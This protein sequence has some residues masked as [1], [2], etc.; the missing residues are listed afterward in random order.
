M[1][2]I[3]EASHRDTTIIQFASHYTAIKQSTEQHSIFESAIVG[4]NKQWA[5]TTQ[6]SS[7]SARSFRISPDY[8]YFFGGFVILVSRFA[9]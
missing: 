8:Y 5:R 7:G 6:F 1:K 9:K 4:R 2:E 3:E